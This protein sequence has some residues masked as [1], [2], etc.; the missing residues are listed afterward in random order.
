MCGRKARMVQVK[1][2]KWRQDKEKQ[3]I[4]KKL[5]WKDNGEEQRILKDGRV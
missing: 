5:G 2:P 4:I 1:A 3:K